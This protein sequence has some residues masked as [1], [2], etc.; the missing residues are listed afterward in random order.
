MKSSETAS[1]SSTN[2]NV[3]PKSENVQPVE[4]DSAAG[5]SEQQDAKVQPVIDS[6]ESTSQVNG[7]H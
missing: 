2:A 7:Q 6:S 5:G 1:G 3:I 4:S